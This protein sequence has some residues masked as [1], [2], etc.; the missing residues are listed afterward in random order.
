LIFFDNISK[1]MIVIH[2]KLLELFIDPLSWKERESDRVKK[3]INVICTPSLTKRR[4][5]G[6]SSWI[7]PWE[8]THPFIPSPRRRGE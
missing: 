6:M 8:G 1:I 2:Q 4:G 5:R 3:M 7:M